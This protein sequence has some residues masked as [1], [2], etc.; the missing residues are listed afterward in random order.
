[1]ALPG[2][3]L[4]PFLLPFQLCLALLRSQPHWPYSRPWYTL[5]PLLG[6]PLLPFWMVPLHPL[7]CTHG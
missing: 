2:L 4:P 7:G 6:V 1:M 3:G 5:L